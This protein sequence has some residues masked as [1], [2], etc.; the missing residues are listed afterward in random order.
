MKKQEKKEQKNQKEQKE[1]AEP[2]IDFVRELKEPQVDIPRASALGFKPKPVLNGK[3]TV[4]IIILL[5]IF[6]LSYLFSSI[7]S[8]S[9]DIKTGNV[10]VIKIRGN[11][12][13]DSVNTLF[14][15]TSSSS[16]LIQLID[17]AEKN[18]G[19]KAILFDINSGGGSPVASDELQ[20]RIKKINKTT[21][22][23][24]R[25][26]AASGAYWIA[27]AADTVFANQMSMTGSIGV[28]GS[29][30]EFVGL[31]DKY[32]LTYRRLVGGE[33][34]DIG[35]PLKEMTPNE[36]AIMQ[37]MINEIHSEFIQSVAE[38]RNLTK[39][40]LDKIKTA[41]IFTGRQA[42][43]LGLVDLLGNEPDA[44]KFMEKKLN[45]TAQP[46]VYE[47]KETF[48]EKIQSL[49]YGKEFGLQSQ[50]KSMESNAVVVKA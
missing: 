4:A 29:Y 26:I 41:E 22:A 13:V 30:V 36:Q 43:E 45:I 6:S 25:D 28:Y 48:W 42:K 37:K 47:K 33:Y 31:L 39:E 21:V 11:I 32:N 44:L 20:Q 50:V 5:V 49:A 14:E 27:S 35:S 19:I 9:S 15:K 10:A 12:A 18:P 38:N 16:D 46:V 1:Q 24:I 40:Q 34:K 17:A 7:L 23:L 3:L 8:S 2:K